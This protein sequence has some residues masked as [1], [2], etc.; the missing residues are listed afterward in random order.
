[1]NCI[2]ATGRMPIM[3]APTAA[4]TIA[5]SAIGVSMTRSSPNS[6]MQAVGHLEGAAVDADVLAEE[7]DPVVAGHLLADSLADGVH[8]GRLALRGRG[9]GVRS[10]EV[11]RAAHDS[12]LTAAGSPCGIPAA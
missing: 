1:M 6:S 9:P 12:L 11:R 10:A 8:V 7:E 4:P 2:S 5:V 3:A